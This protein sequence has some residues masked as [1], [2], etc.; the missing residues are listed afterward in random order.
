M[1]R[2]FS[3]SGRAVLV[4]MDHG[5]H[6]VFSLIEGLE[7]FEA[8]L[9]TVV[10]ASP[11][12]ILLSPGQASLLQSMNSQHRPALVLRCDVTNVY[13][14]PRFS[15]EYC[16]LIPESVEAA[17]SLDACAVLLNLFHCRSNP[18]LHEQCIE[19][20]TK[21]KPACNR[22]GMPLIVEP[23]ILEADS[24]D[25]VY[26]MGGKVEEVVA[27]HRQAVELGAD[28]LKA[29]PSEDVGRYREV[30]E[31]VGN[32]PLLPRG[33]GRVSSREILERTHQLVS[34]G[35]SGVVYGRNIFLN[36]DVKGMLRAIKAIIHQDRDVE[37]A[38]SE[39]DRSRRN[40]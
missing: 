25:A 15:E 26:Q 1:N 18:V 23:L 5:A 31:A 20:L 13:G 17:L 36:E 27:L 11:D 24:E 3:S 10:S 7:A 9:D 29:D 6:N 4:A 22:F 8:T 35:A 2:L 37:S 38:L 30:V 28:L 21:I 33:G 32:V 19:N 16:R 12:A 40:V 14:T 34:A 39:L